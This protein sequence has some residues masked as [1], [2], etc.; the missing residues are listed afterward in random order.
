MN[1]E[2]SESIERN[3]DRWWYDIISSRTP[4]PESG[5]Q[6]SVYL[7]IYTAEMALQLPLPKNM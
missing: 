5:D 3:L 1:E 7:T 4:G 2:N 6:L